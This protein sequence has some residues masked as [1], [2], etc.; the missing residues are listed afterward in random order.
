MP[1]RWKKDEFK[2]SQG[3]T[4]LEVL[5]VLAILAGT[6]FILLVKI[7]VQME[8]RNLSLASTR[9]MQDLREARQSA[10]A[11]RIYYEVRFYPS[12]NTYRIYRQSDLQRS[13]SLPQGIS[14][15]NTP[16]SVRFG[17]NGNVV[18][19]GTNQTGIVA[20]TNGKTTRHIITALIS[21][22]VREEIR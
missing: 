10:L 14:Y 18:F 2:K 16:S 17:A 6:G 4:L 9:L 1:C 15:A 19:L 22:R 8:E 13:Q 5:L 7:P 12:N 3:F 11:E 20:L 21:G